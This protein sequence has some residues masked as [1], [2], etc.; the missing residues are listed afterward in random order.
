MMELNENNYLLFSAKYYENPNC[1]DISEFYSDLSI[2]VHI[3]K[4]LS[5]YLSSGVLKE[6][7][8]LNHLICFFNVFEPIAA[9]KIL[10]FKIEEIHHVNLKTVLVFLDR[11]PDFLKVGN[12]DLKN[13]TTNDNLLIE[14][15]NSVAV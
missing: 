3:K 14:L 5:K 12:K 7:L 15:K 10:F 13:I 2:I 9:I 6:R 4:L 11:C 8:L 1:M